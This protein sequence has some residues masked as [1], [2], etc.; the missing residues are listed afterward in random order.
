[1]RLSARLLVFFGESIPGNSK[2]EQVQSS[3]PHSVWSR[4]TGKHV[5]WELYWAGSCPPAQSQLVLAARVAGLPSAWVNCCYFC[6]C[7]CIPVY[8]SMCHR[9]PSWGDTTREWGPL[10]QSSSPYKRQIVSLEKEWIQ[11]C[12]SLGFL[13]FFLSPS[14]ISNTAVG[15]LF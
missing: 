14:P 1:M 6:V 12:I 8:L 13:D 11:T 5:S 4:K 9:K 3:S 10:L 7:E 2:A 15:H